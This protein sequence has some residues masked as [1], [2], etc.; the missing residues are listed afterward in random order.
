MGPYTDINLFQPDLDSSTF[1]N[2]L[3]QDSDGDGL[4]DGQ[5]DT[6]RNGRWDEGETVS[7]VANGDFNLD[8]IVDL[9]DLIL[10]L[11]TLT[12]YPMATL[13]NV[14]ADTDGNHKLDMVDG[15][16]I[17]KKID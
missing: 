15:L 4:L 3:A 13:I 16:F 6:N 17:L 11:K 8:S 5:E 7:D 10:L 1:S 12:D 2:P 14:R 9:E